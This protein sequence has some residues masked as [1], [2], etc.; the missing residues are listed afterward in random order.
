MRLV[1]V[2]ATWTSVHTIEVPDDTPKL[3]DNDL[4]G[5]LE[6]SGDDIQSNVAELTDW[7]ITDDGPQED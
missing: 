3:A 4:D 1:T 7:T 6:A 2:R 5:L